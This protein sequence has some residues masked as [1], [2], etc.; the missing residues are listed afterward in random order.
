VTYLALAKKSFLF[1]SGANLKLCVNCFELKFFVFR[2]SCTYVRSN[3]S[4][5]CYVS[6]ENAASFYDA[7]IVDLCPLTL[8]A[9]CSLVAHF[10][11]WT[12]IFRLAA[13]ALAAACS[14]P[15]AP[16]AAAPG[17]AA[18]GAAAPGT[19]VLCHSAN[20]NRSYFLLPFCD[21]FTVCCSL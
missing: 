21:L 6:P 19:A 11:T 20:T 4:L 16:C 5:L 2:T 13:I 9:T 12:V 3:F 1:G 14:W 15:S 8:A 17:A 18:P 10:V 7:H